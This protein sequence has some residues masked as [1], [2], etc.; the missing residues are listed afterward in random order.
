MQYPI[1][2]FPSSSKKYSGTVEKVSRKNGTT[3]FICRIRTRGFY[4]CKSFQN[5]EDALEHLKEKNLEFGLR[6]K[7]T[8]REWP[9]YMEVEVKEG[10]WSKFDKE[11]LVIIEKYTWGVMSTGYVI[12]TSEGRTLMLHNLLLAHKPG[13]ITID[14][15]DR[16][17]LNNRKNNLRVANKSTQLINQKIKS[18]NTSG[19][20]GVSYQNKCWTARWKDE[21]GFRTKYFSI[22]KYGD[23]GA[24]TLAIAFRKHVEETVPHYKKALND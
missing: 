15:I 20:K 14:H 3:S 13:E 19:T 7:N 24:K 21:K 5:H 22:K 16:D 17:P 23:E 1:T 2:H 8:V 18:T 9:E 10:I 11:G 6:I 12:T 4:C